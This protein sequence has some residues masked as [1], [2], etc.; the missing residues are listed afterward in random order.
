MR[1]RRDAIACTRPHTSSVIPKRR[2]IATARQS[3]SCV[4]ARP[5]TRS[6]KSGPSFDK[7]SSRGPAAKKLSEPSDGARS[8]NSTMLGVPL[9]AVRKA[10]RYVRLHFAELVRPLARLA[11][12]AEGRRI[13]VR[14]TDGR[15]LVDA[16]TSPFVGY[17]DRAS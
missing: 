5:S 10:A 4:A 16:T 3:R 9:L 15:A 13:L 8:T 2:S 17:L 6:M 12:V 11:L 7:R 1:D 14:T